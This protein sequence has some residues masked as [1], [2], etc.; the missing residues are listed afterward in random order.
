MTRVAIVGTTSW[1]TTLAVL[2]ARGGADVSLLARSVAEADSINAARENARH[3]P[4][5]KL[6]SNVTATIDPEAVATADA[7]VLAVPSASL[8]ANLTRLAPA[9]SP[10]SSVLSATKGIEPESCLR[11]SQVV[12]SF[13]IEAVRVLVLSGPNFAGEIAAGLPAATVVA[14]RDEARAREAQALLNGPSF[15][16]YTSDDPVG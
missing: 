16:V 1:G 15:R 5:L 6:P 13:G 10:A 9:I 8:R 4:G 14:G 11:M 7:V 2:A 12:E 3:R